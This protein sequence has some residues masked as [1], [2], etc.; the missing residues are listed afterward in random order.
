[1]SHRFSFA[2]FSRSNFPPKVEQ[3][4]HHQFMKEVKPHLIGGIVSGGFTYFIFQDFTDQTGAF[5]WLS[6]QLLLAVSSF[7]LYQLHNKHQARLHSTQWS[8]VIF[9]MASLWGL[10][11]S[12]PAFLFLDINNIE[13]LAS[14]VIFVCAMT[15]SPAPG[16]AIYP[17]AYSMFLSLPLL[18]L[19]MQ[20][21]LSGYNSLLVL[22]IPFFW[23]GTLAYGWQLH[24]TI[25]DSICLRIDLEQARHD[26]ESANLAKSNF[27]AAASHD[28]RQPLQAI[29]LL[30]SALRL[31]LDLNEQDNLANKLEDSIDNLSELLNTLLDVSKLDAGAVQ[32]KREHV[33]LSS[34]LKKTLHQYE[35]IAQQKQLDFSYDLAEEIVFVDPNILDRV[36]QNLLSNALRYTEQGYVR[37]KA[38][39]YDKTLTLSVE[40]SG[41][42][43]AQDEQDAIFDEFYQLGN[44]ERDQRKG[45]GLG[46]A[47]VKR[48]CALQSWP[49][50][51]ESE[52]SKGSTFSVTLPIGDP[53][54]VSTQVT[55]PQTLG[56]FD[57]NKVILIDD[58]KDIRSAM[59]SLLKGWNCDVKAFESFTHATEALK[60]SA[61][62]PWQPELVISDFRLRQNQNG[63]DTINSIQRHYESNIP[64]I[65]ITGDT[66]PERLQQARESGLSVL[67]KPIKAAQLRQVLQ[68]TFSAERL[69]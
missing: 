31:K 57:S 48:L 65:L 8:Y 67:H 4:R 53:S 58:D 19:G 46:L 63:I 45:I 15:I 30:F 29:E 28:L 51:L 10:V 55:K 37:L 9:A 56:M 26:A 18:S 22:G 25:T 11:W 24:K 35:A 49:I 34:A 41:I 23:L 54:Q 27:L 38:S 61:N 20:L 52:L 36:V 32:V 42:G 2:R 47:I 17:F 5:I 40:D 59:T 33:E 50:T 64:S 16:M 13:Y 43:I 3:A 7:G 66:A 68:Q 21:W 62:D 6:C 1:M 14:L 39:V 12:L 60:P 69:T 44:P